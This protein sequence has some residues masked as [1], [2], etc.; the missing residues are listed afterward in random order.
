MADVDARDVAEEM[1]AHPSPVV[2]AGDLAAE[3][4]CSP[5]HALNLLRGLEAADV[6]ES[7]ETGA[8]AVAWWH[9]D[10]V[11]PPN[12]DSHDDA[13]RDAHEPRPV[14][15]THRDTH[16]DRD[17]GGGREQHDDE[18]REAVARAA[19]YWEDD[20]RLDDRREAALA[21]L[22]AVRESEHGL[23][24]SEILDRFADEYAV[25]GQSEGT[26]WRR[27]L[28][29]G[30]E[31]ADAPAPLQLVA[32]YSRGTHKWRWAGLDGDGE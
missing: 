24:K 5:R 1:L 4:D 30:A 7:R 25:E 3:L 9:R 31:D 20:D 22:D 8:R 11:R 16:P 28:A 27:N 21:V 19:E 29:E 13:E 12:P 17:G 23:T 2:T 15:E 10:R 6:V 32:E 26:W 18:V 14:G